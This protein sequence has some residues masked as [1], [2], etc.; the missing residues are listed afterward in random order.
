[1]QTV[2]SAVALRPSTP[3]WRLRSLGG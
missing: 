1:M 3:R 2:R